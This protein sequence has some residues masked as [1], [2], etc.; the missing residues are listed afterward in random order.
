VGFAG[1]WRGMTAEQLAALSSWLV[2][3]DPAEF[4]C[5]GCLGADQQAAEVACRLTRA[6]LIVHRQP[7]AKIESPILLAVAS[8]VLPPD[9][10]DG[11]RNVALVNASDVIAL[12]PHSR[13]DSRGGTYRTFKFARWVNKWNGRKPIML[14]WP[15]GTVEEYVESSAPAAETGGNP[16]RESAADLAVV[17]SP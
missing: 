17:A 7:V 3:I 5:G 10:A 16:S 9:P 1:Y 6:K 15:D 13:D 14:F 4:R 12:A 11:K 2:S 8:K